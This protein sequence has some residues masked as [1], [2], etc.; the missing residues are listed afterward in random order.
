MQPTH[1]IDIPIVHGYAALVT[2]ETDVVSFASWR[3][4]AGPCLTED[5]PSSTIHSLA[6]LN[7]EGSQINHYRRR[8]TLYFLSRD[9]FIRN[10]DQS[11]FIGQVWPG[12]TVRGGILYAHRLIACF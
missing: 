3:I 7:C 8:R 9:V 6:E 11:V 4:Q 10:P 2:N 12:Y 1:Q 5:P